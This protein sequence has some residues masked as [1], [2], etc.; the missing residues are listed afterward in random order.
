MQSLYIELRPID[1]QRIELRY[2]HVEVNEGS[3]EPQIV[4]I[5]SIQSLIAQSER[6]F[7]VSSFL[8]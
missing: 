6:D 8:Y 4:D 1:K 7:Y 2:H 5:S 3:Y